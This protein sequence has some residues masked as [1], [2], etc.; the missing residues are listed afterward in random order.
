MIVGG[1]QENTIFTAERL[2]KEIYQVKVVSGPQTGAEG[3]LIQTARE[4]SVNL[5]ILPELVREI[6]PWKDLRSLLQLYRL[7]ID[8]RYLIVHTHSSKAGILGRLAAKMA[9][10]P[11]ILHTVHGWSFHDRMSGL[12]KQV[13]IQLEKWFARITDKLIV[14]TKRDI[15]KGLKA[16]IGK[17]AQYH[18]IR[19]AIP[20]DQYDP[21]KYN[22]Y[23]VRNELGIPA[24]APVVGNVGRLS[25]QKNPLDWV[26]VAALISEEQPSCWFLLVGDGPM[27]EEVENLCQS[28]GIQDRI[29]LT[30]IR[31]DV[32]RLLSVMDVFLLTSL[33]EGLPR[34][35]PQAMSMQ[36]PVV[37]NQVDGTVEV[38]TPGITGYLSDPGD[39]RQAAKYCLNLLR[40]PGLCRNMGEASRLYSCREFGLNR[41]MEDIESLYERLLIGLDKS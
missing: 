31:R 32:P 27:R 33:W 26:R 12:R 40:D 41:M 6:H 36:V 38:I 35:I 1:A 24:D 9:G 15:A 17:E 11:I 37:A 30:G 18:L 13:F 7:I 25:P 3:S 39:I 2:N 19:S 14:V 20:L 28:L 5:E 4:L 21:T 22:R 23:D 10:V 8:S 29:I 34:V 16:G